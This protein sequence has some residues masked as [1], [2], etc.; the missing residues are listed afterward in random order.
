MRAG[1]TLKRYL[2]T[3]FINLFFLFLFWPSLTPRHEKPFL[4]FARVQDPNPAKSYGESWLRRR[5]SGVEPRIMRISL[6]AAGQKR[7]S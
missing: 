5:S 7:K 2:I 3:V 6:M 4:A 1:E